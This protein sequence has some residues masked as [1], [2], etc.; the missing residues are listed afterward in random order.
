[1]K[2]SRAFYLLLIAVC[3]IVTIF[4]IRPYHPTTLRITLDYESSLCD[5]LNPSSSDITLYLILILIL[6]LILNLIL[7]GWSHILNCCLQLCGRHGRYFQLCFQR[8][9]SGQVVQQTSGAE[10]E[11]GE[12]AARREWRGLFFKHGWQPQAG[13]LV[14]RLQ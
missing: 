9:K 13:I 4:S 1:M 12:A 8:P 3:L 6:I 2:Y 7:I 14:D 11:L 10:Q 5:L